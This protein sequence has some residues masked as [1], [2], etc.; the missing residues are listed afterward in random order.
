MYKNIKF[1]ESAEFLI[2]SLEIDEILDN[3]GDE[4]VKIAEQA[5]N[6]IYELIQ[7]S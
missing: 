7:K 6:E 1:S 4:L 3:N 5:Y 2:G